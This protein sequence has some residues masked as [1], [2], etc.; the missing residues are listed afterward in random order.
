MDASLEFDEKG[1]LE[2]VEDLTR[3]LGFETTSTE[4]WL[5]LWLADINCVREL[6][7]EAGSDRI[8]GLFA[9]DSTV[10]RD[11]MRMWMGCGR[12]EHDD[13]EGELYINSYTN[14]SPNPQAMINKQSQV[15]YRSDGTAI[16]EKRRSVLEI[17]SIFPP[18]LADD[19]KHEQFWSTLQHFWSP[20]KIASWRGAARDT[21]ACANWITFARNV[22]AY[23]DHGM[24]TMK[25]IEQSDDKAW[26]IA[27]TYWL[28]RAYEESR[29]NMCSRPF[30]P[31]D[32]E[33]SPDQGGLYTVDGKKIVSGHEVNPSTPDPVNLPLS[34]FELLE[35]RW[36][37]DR[38]AGLAGVEEKY[39]CEN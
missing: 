37:L 24:M 19:P 4:A 33:A 35:M 15:V 8:K 14:S 2:A 18:N 3:A 1:R 25:P 17:Y 10:M 26:S 5:A 28:P 36:V 34:S 6:A 39:G 27:H 22:G 29:M 7:K 21:K 31:S 11:A 9:P 13:D 12:K 32:L 38:I 23:W 20:S 16:I 30:I